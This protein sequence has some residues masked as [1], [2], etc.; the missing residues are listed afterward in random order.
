MIVDDRYY[1]VTT[2]GS[3]SERLLIRGETA[4]TRISLRLARPNLRTPFSILECP[5]S[6]DG[7]N[8]LVRL[9]PYPHHITACG[10][11]EAKEFQSAFAQVRYRQ[12]VP[13]APLPFAEKSFNIATSNAELEHAGGVEDQRQFVAEMAR[14]A[15]RTFI[16]VPHR[17][18]PIE[19]HTAIPFAR[20]TDATFQIACAA[21]T[22]AEVG[23]EHQLRA[24]VA[25]ETCVHCVGRF[26]LP[27]WLHGSAARSAQFQSVPRN[28]LKKMGW[29]GTI[30]SSATN[31]VRATG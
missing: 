2:P 6:Y 23:R 4:S 31:K 28:Q 8:M 13:R 10:L 30:A 15:R 22:K 26:A 7:A 12:V 20:W 18:F 19:H 17:F 9:Y 29:V 14:V 3:L 11:G 21:Q 24:D 27:H 16:T 5:M 25:V 1:E